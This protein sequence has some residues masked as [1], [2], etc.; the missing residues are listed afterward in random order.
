[1]LLQLFPSPQ[2]SPPLSSLVPALPPSPPQQTHSLQMAS[3]WYTV[4]LQLVPVDACRVGAFISTLRFTHMVEDRGATHEGT[5]IED[6]P[7]AAEGEEAS[8]A[9]V[10]RAVSRTQR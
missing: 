5:Q 8:K 9:A 6:K 10:K 2:L 7:P 4:G 1:M 3:S